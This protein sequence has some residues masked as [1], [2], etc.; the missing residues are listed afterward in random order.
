MQFGY[1]LGLPGGTGSAWKKAAKIP[2]T[3]AGPIGYL[4]RSPLATFSMQFEYFLG[5]P[6]GI[7]SDRKKKLPKIPAERPGHSKVYWVCMYLEGC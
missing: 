5:L 3:R 2:G 6:R 1:F 4:F 7:A